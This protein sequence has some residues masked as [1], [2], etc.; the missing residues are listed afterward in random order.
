MNCKEFNEKYE[1]GWC[2]TCNEGF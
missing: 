2:E 1:L